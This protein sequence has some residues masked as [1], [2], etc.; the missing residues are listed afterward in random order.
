M[1]KETDECVWNKL[2]EEAG[3]EETVIIVNPNQVARAMNLCDALSVRFVGPDVCI[4]IL[5]LCGQLCRDILPEEVMK[6]WPEGRLAVAFI[7]VMGR[8]VVE[9]NGSV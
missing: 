1:D 6:Q 8:C 4:P 5:V 7:V 9:P 3:D 2:T